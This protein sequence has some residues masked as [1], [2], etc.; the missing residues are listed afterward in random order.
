[1]LRRLVIAV[2]LAA[3]ASTAQ[4][5]ILDFNLSD[6][7]LRASMSGPLSLG[8]HGGAQYDFGYMY[9][10]K[11][12]ARLNLGHIGLMVTGDAGA[13]DA[14][15]QAGLGLRGVVLGMR[16]S[17]NGGAVAVGGNFDVRLPEFNRIGLI[18]SLWFAPSVL[19]FGDAER[20]SD[21]SVALDYEV[22]RNASLYVG[23]REV[24]VKVDEQV[25]STLRDNS[26]LLGMRLHF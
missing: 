3:A 5:E 4:A 21:L 17:N 10:D 13:R 11:R 8:V 24:R 15:V 2:G 20:Y 23:F 6:E 26:V 25:G 18:G 12:D 7:A 22:I 16:H 1:M 9:S 19:A 14:N